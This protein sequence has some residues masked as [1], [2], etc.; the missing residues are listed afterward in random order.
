MVA[1]IR[2][3]YGNYHEL[4]KS[5]YERSE[6]HAEIHDEVYKITK[7]S[8]HFDACLVFEVAIHQRGQRRAGDRVLPVCHDT[9]LYSLLPR[10]P[11]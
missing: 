2:P 7:N 3:R 9:F 8:I 6:A 10:S 5:G 11:I 1:H 4:L